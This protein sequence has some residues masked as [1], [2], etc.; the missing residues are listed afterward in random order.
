MLFESHCFR[1]R[2]RSRYNN[3][4]PSDCVKNVIIIFIF[5]SFIFVFT[6]YIFYSSVDFARTSR[7]TSVHQSNVNMINT[8]NENEKKKKLYY[9]LR[10]EERKK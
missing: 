8:H 1:D 9:I 6:S 5:F 4:K 10:A 2:R 7:C 3:A